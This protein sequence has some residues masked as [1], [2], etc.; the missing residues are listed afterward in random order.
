M[1]G[2]EYALLPSYLPTY[3]CVHNFP[4]TGLLVFLV[5]LLLLLLAPGLL[6]APLAHPY[7]PAAP[8]TEAASAREWDLG[9]LV[10]SCLSCTTRQCSSICNNVN[11]RS[12]RSGRGRSHLT[13]LT[14]GPA[15]P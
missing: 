14:G 9:L 15:S 12:S 2:Y 3:A 13:S 5:S 7:T 10:L 6:Q 11:G 8:R 1:G 4:T